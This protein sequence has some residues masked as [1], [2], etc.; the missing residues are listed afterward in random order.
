MKASQKKAMDWLCLYFHHISNIAEASFTCMHGHLKLKHAC[1]GA[2]G[3]VVNN[4]NKRG[5][6][7]QL[8]NV[9]R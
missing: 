6:Y 3:R 9:R 4:Y 7:F 1:Q 8:I 2:R 5:R